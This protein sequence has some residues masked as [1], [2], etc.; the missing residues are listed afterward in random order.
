M[1]KK[2]FLFTSLNE[3]LLEIFF[4]IKTQVFVI[5]MIFFFFLVLFAFVYEISGGFF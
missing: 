1:S 2:K 4:Y 3:N 5:F